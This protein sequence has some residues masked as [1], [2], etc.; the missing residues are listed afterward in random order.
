MVRAT[1]LIRNVVIAAVAGFGIAGLTGSAGA[2]DEP[3]VSFS[4][5]I[6]PIFKASC[7]KCH[8]LDNPR[9][10]ASAGFRLDNRA[11]ALKGG[12]NAHEKDI[13]PGNAKESVLYQLLFK[14]VTVEG[15]DVEAMPKHKKGQQFKP[16]PEKQINLIKAWIDQGAKFDN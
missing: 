7:I 4:K 8:S 6:Q 10:K 15:E 13:V 1:G 11:E 12:D 16:L 2:A 5:D 14:T 9:H 3:Q